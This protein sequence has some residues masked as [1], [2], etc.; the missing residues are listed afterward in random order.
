M[1]N[2]YWT[3]WVKIVDKESQWTTMVEGQRQSIDIDDQKS[4]DGGWTMTVEGPSWL[5]GTDAQQTNMVE[6]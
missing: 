6:G 1:V 3:N 5:T 4:K 2:G